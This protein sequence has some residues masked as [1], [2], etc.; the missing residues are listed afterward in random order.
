MAVR[1]IVEV[2][3]SVLIFTLREQYS[4]WTM[5][6]CVEKMLV[7]CGSELG[8]Y[9]VEGHLDAIYVFVWS[10]LSCISSMGAVRNFSPVQ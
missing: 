10:L 5:H 6:L 2:M 4:L 9:F 1:H 3:K 7:F 8:G